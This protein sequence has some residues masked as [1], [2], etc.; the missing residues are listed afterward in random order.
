M[1]M[2]TTWDAGAPS[3]VRQHTPSTSGQPE[4]VLEESEYLRKLEAEA[5]PAADFCRQYYGE[6]EQAMLGEAAV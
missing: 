3:G 2:L 5:I 6:K 1:A 4:P